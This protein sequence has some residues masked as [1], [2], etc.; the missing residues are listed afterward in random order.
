[1]KILVDSK[2]NMVEKETDSRGRITLGTEY[3]NRKVTLAILNVK[4]KDQEV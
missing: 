1:M 3:A 2:E 4:E